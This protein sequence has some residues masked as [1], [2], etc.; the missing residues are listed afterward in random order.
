MKSSVAA[1]AAASLA[2]LAL[3]GCSYVNPITTHENY[4]ASDGTQLI[5]G[6]VEALNLIVITTGV[7][8]PAT[9]VGAVQNDSAEDIDLQIS[10]DGE[11]TSQLTVPAQDQVRLGPDADAT[12]S[13]TAPVQPGLLA[14]VTLVSEVEGAYTIDVPVMDGTLPEYAPIVEQIG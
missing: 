7:G 2:A 10:F 14:E 12:V 5:V 4:A 11:T 3:A 9:L 6:D 13:G 1:G 8:E